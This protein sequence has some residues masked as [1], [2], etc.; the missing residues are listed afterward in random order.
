MGHIYL[1]RKRD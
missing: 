1:C